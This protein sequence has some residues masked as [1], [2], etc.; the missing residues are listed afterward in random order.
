MSHGEPK[1]R[2]DAM[3]PPPLPKVVSYSDAP[4]QVTRVL[5][6]NHAPAVSKVVVLLSVLLSL[7]VCISIGL[8]IQNDNL[9][10]G[11]Q[12]AC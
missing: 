5:Q 7:F 4:A 10:R 1:P 6:R 11:N 3:S 12:F 9:R 2:G 8:L